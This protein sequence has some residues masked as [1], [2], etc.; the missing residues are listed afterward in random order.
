MRR[1]PVL[2]LAASLAGCSA[3]SPSSPSSPG[4]SASP[5]TS[6][7][8][9]VPAT[10]SG[11]PVPSLATD[12]NGIAL[13]EAHLPRLAASDTDARS[14]GTAVDAF[15]LALYAQAKSG[16]GNVVISPAS[17]A[18]ALS[19][20]RAG[21]R[22]TTAD[23]MDAVLHDLATDG[24]A[25]W[26]ASLDQALAAR[27]GSFPDLTGQAQQVTLRIA[28]APFA[29]RDMTLVPAYLDALSARF[30]AGVRL[31]DY[32]T[33]A[34]PA[35]TAINSWVADQTEQRIKNLL[36]AGSVTDMTRLVLVNAIYLKAA[37][38]KPFDAQATAAAPFHL[39]SGSTVQAQMM[40][41]GGEMPYAAGS[42][43]KAVELPYVGNKLASFEA[44]FDA[45]T[46]A[47]ITGALADRQVVL[48]LPKF[49]AQSSLSLSE[50]LQ[51][52]GMPTAFGGSAD[53]TGITTDEPLAI[54]DVI[55]QANI[56]VDEKGTTAAAATAVM[57]AATGML[58]DQVTLTVDHP[59]LFAVRD[60]DTGAVLFL[61]R[62][63]DPTLAA[64]K[65]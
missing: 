46:L 31:V 39:A 12:A 60:L 20:A 30:G 22:G 11:T 63:T 58:S 62:I 53:F 61:G 19:M 64:P 41:T 56:D 24:H 65:N 23:E 14:A 59:F 25:S 26:V 10:P 33:A 49:S 36:G 29:Q 13:A 57:V 15:G 48:G 55:H 21:A 51:A 42:G 27:T 34:E 52:M 32:K 2:L 28:N 1:L 37:W 6:A 7:T 44:H 45:A 43:W 5:G 4:A 9:G 40:G 35:R 17:V 50:A 54:S 38:L 8:P 3:A 18:V 16:T 47:S